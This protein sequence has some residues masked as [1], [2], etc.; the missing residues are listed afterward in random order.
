MIEVGRNNIIIRNVDKNSAGYKSMFKQFSLYDRV[1]H[2]YTFSIFQEEGNDIYLP[3]SVT[4]PVIQGFFPKKEVTVNFQRTAK[5]KSIMYNM[6]HQ[7]VNQLQSDAI[8]FLMKM[9]KDPETH[10]RFLSLETGSGKTYVTINLIS[11]LRKKALIIVDTIELASQ[12]AREFSKH[13]D[14]S[15]NKVVILSGQ[16]SIDKEVANPTGDV[17]IAIHRTLGNMMSADIN[18]INTLMNKL[19]IGIRIF[20][21]SHVEFG[22]ICRINSF[23][24]VEYTLYLTATPN[25]SAYQDDSLYAKVFRSV[26]YYNGKDLSPGKY[27]TVV[28]YKMNTH[29][30]FDD[31]LSVRTQHGF[32]Q[33]KWSSYAANDGYEHFII[34]VKDIFDNFKLIERD[35]KTAI[36]LP[37]IELIKK[38]KNDLEDLFPGIEIGTFIGEIPKNKR[39]DELTKKFILTN[40]KIFDK[41]IDIKDLEI[42]INFV[43]IGSQVKTEQ[44]IGRLRRKEGSS[45]VLIDV[46]DIG[47]DE[48]IRQSKLR[49]RFYKKK[50]KK[51]IDLKQD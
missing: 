39:A 19:G 27:H 15:P 21:E 49:K 17:Y 24:N 50:A 31:R 34:A 1:L 48:C 43:P 44:I 9:K 12:W 26:P 25:R 20:D 18:S 46:T 45:S 22:N 14:I 36:M 6:I 4:L 41:G 29:P 11:K 3:A 13:T 42:L 37:T 40:D 38:L 23:S 35:K 8:T 5:P 10:Q 32:N 2:K 30:S 28:L 51:I 7:P 16:A 47:F 33:A